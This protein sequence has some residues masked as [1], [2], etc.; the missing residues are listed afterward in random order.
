MRIVRSNFANGRLCS[1]DVSAALAIPG[2]HEVWTA[3]DVADLPPIDFRQS[4]LEGLE[5]YRQPMLAR[6]KYVISVSR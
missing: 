2:V 1:I 4:R 5:H 6:T 3:A